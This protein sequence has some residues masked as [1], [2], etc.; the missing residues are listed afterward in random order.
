M[1]SGISV[2]KLHYHIRPFPDTVP[3]KDRLENEH[4]GNMDQY[5]ATREVPLPYSF[6]DQAHESDG[7]ED[8]HKSV[9]SWR[10]K[11]KASKKPQ[12][13]AGHN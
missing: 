8:D 7:D 5:R 11:R 10:S 2:S 13:D 3:L 4:L 12:S 1:F 9:S 6:D